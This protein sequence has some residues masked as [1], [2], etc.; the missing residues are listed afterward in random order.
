[1]KTRLFATFL[2]ALFLLSFRVSAQSTTVTRS[3]AAF[4]K[5]AISGG[6][7][8]VILKEGAA[9]GVSID[10]NGI[11]ADKIKTEINGST[12]EIGIKK[13]TY[14]NY[15]ARITVTYKS[16]SGIANSGSSDVEAQSTIKAEHFSYAGSGSG[17]FRGSFDVKKLEIAISGSSDMTLK[18]QAEK[19]EI[20]ISGSGDVNASELKGK[21]ASVA[22]SGSGDVKLN[23]S[24]PVRSMV[25]GSGDVSNNN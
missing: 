4:D 1:M 14:G 8:A 24:G 7:D 2:F 18:G 13:G 9:E 15:K 22:I 20:A 16:I 5:I 11:D 17:D 23:V 6:F 25:S 3:L 12:L 19:Q 10:V 21:E